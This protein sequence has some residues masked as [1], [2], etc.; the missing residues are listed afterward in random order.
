MT[1]TELLTEWMQSEQQEQIKSQTYSR[2]MSL[3]G[4]HILPAIGD[5][6]I[7]MLTRRQISDFLLQK[8]HSGN[9]RC[10]GG[11]SPVSINMML[12][13]LNMAFNYAFDREYIENNPC[14][15]VKR[16]PM[17]EQRRIDAFTKDEQIRIERT[18]EAEEDDRLFGIILCFY[19]GL[20][21]GELIGLEWSD[22]NDS[23]RIMSVSKTV[24]RE[25]C[26]NGEWRL[27]VDKPKTASSYRAIP[28]PEHIAADLCRLRE[29]SSS[30]YIVQNKKGERMSIRSYQY[31]FE[32]ITEKA[33]VRKLNF[34]AIRHTFATRAL[35]NGIDIKTLSEIMGH[36]NASITL[37]RYAHSMMDTKIEMMKKMTRII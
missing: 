30:V 7:S 27:C 33:G 35:E 15:R 36:K 12:S 22:M 9:R 23:C 31:I 25:R 11:L 8:R 26:E 28:L 29:K 17:V 18:I 3:I 19:T 16:I 21:I 13:I 14:D 10:D 4:L 20:R 32:K 24:Y 2:Y 37:N 34:H 1:T 6:N 5:R